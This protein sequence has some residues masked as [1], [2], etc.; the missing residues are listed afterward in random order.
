MKESF[1]AYYKKIYPGTISTEALEISDN[2]ELDEIKITGHYSIPNIWKPAAQPNFVTCEFP[3]PG[4]LSSLFIP[5]KTDRA[6]DL[7]VLFPENIIHHVYIETYWP[8]RFIP[9]EKKI[10]VKSFLYY[11]KTYGTN[12]QIRLNN[13]LVTSSAAVVPADVQEYLTA[14]AQIPHFLGLTLTKPVSGT[15]VSARME[16]GSPNW[17]IWMAAIFYTIILLIA[18]TGVY[19]F[20]PKVAPPVLP[21]PDPQLNGLG[22]WLTL[23]ALGLIVTFLARVFV[24]IRTCSFFSLENWRAYTDPTSATYNGMAA[25]VLL[26]ELFTQ[27]TLLVFG[28]LLLILFFQ[29]RRIFPK[30]FIIFLLVHLV[31]VT[32]DREL[33]KGLNSPVLD[34]HIP[35]VQN[36][37]RLLVPLIAWG[38]YLNRSKRVKSTF[39]Q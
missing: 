23:L 1:L 18:A 2:D 38:L 31:A 19:R 37:A 34:T 7:A 24:L 20:K 17:S 6:M 3:S 8:W 12:G 15:V 30:L 36:I 28:I 22:G 25:P 27:L 9:T 33:V 10:Q 14:V 13:Q 29:K 32:L 26:Y 39:Q 21:S 16:R 35:P 5:T 4:I 11:S